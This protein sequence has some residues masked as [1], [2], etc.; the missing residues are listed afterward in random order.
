MLGY[1]ELYEI[2]RKEKYSEIL[3]ALPKNFSEEFVVFLSDRKGESNNEEGLF[4]DNIAKSKKQF[5]NS[6][7]LFRELFR[8]RKRKLL[9]LVFVATETGIMKRDYENMLGFE[10]E[11]FD[12]LVKGFEGFDKEISNLL[13]GG[14]KQE[15][16][17]LRMIMF[18]QDVD[19]F[20]DMSGKVVGPYASGE[21]ANLDR[22]VAD[23]FVS[24]GKASFVDEG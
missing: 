5:E 15:K 14:K 22:E 11:V 1:N 4:T 23:I 6:I 18:S 19:Q 10:R 16:S 17:K 12:N 3:Q 8:I 24:G 9:S 21:L 7:A 20:V 2:L 13:M